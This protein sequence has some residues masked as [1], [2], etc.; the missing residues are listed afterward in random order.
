[1]R[2]I[3]VLF[4]FLVITLPMSAASIKE[5]PKY[6]YKG[7]LGEAADDGFNGQYA[8]ACCVRNRLRKGM[9]HGLVAMK[10]KDLSDYVYKQPKEYKQRAKR[11][12][13]MVFA[14]NTPDTTGGAIYF[15]N[16]QKYGKPKFCHRKTVKI[17]EHT[18]FRN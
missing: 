11:I 4:L 3:F 8:V 17:G 15:E 1:M 2:S 7:L 13:E 14:E 18:F 16:T 9:W 5:P 6:L 12:V 10:R